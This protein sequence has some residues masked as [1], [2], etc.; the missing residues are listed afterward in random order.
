MEFIKKSLSIIKI[1]VLSLLF[2]IL[3]HFVS[4]GAFA[5]RLFPTFPEGTTANI[6]KLAYT[7]IAF[8]IMFWLLKRWNRSVNDTYMDHSVFSKKIWGYGIGGYVIIFV[9]SLVFLYVKQHIAGGP[10]ESSRIIQDRFFFE[11]GMFAAG[12]TGLNSLIFK[13]ILEEMTFRLGF[14]G[15]LVEEDVPQ[16]IAILGTS[17]VFAWFHG[18]IISQSF[19]T[20]IGLSIL[21]L[22]SKSIYPAMIAH[23]LINTSVLVIRWYQYQ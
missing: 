4:L 23:V 15:Q 5:E 7:I 6:I 16:W 19:I 1:I 13:P 12:I 9:L 20:G 3:V 18:D 17:V 11:E 10:Q 8:I 2:T 21:T 22:K 14:L